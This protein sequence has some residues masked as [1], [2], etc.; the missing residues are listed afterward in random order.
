ME[1]NKYKKDKDSKKVSSIN[2]AS[3]HLNLLKHL[4]LNLSMLVRDL[5]EEYF[6]K[7]YPEKLKKFKDLDKKD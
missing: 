3:Y 1:T 5:L 4:G 2:L 6:L 7:Y